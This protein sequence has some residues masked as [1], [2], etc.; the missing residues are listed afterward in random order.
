LAQVPAFSGWLAGDVAF[1]GGLLS[2]FAAFLICVAISG[3]NPRSRC[4]HC[5]HPRLNAALAMA[6]EHCENCGQSVPFDRP[7]DAVVIEGPTP[8]TPD[9]PK[10]PAVADFLQAWQA[11]VRYSFRVIAYPTIAIMFVSMALVL[12]VLVNRTPAAGIPR[13]ARDF[14]AWLIFGSMFSPPMLYA[15]VA[16]CRWRRPELL[17]CPH[18]R[19][20]L[21]QLR[22]VVVASRHC[23]HCGG[24]VLRQE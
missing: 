10:L 3:T 4:P 11:Y 8:A 15:V 5:R 22:Q 16:T 21:M 18:C 9:N 6:T 23:G 1:G 20:P 24:R 2:G 19:K 7:L 14:V 12:A 13:P 17:S